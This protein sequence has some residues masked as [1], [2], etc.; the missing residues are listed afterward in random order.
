M[1]PTGVVV[2]RIAPLRRLLGVA[3]PGIFAV[4]IWWAVAASIVHREA[5]WPIRD[6]HPS[7]V[8]TVILWV[9]LL[10]VGWVLTYLMLFSLFLRQTFG[11]QGATLRKVR[12]VWEM[13]LASLTRI[14]FQGYMV[15]T[16]TT[17][18]PAERLVVHSDAGG[19]Y[20]LRATLNGGLTHLDEAFEVI[21]GW[22][23]LR[24]ELVRASNAEEYFVQRG[25]ASRR[26]EE[27]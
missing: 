22:V 21:D 19:R 9:L 26:P 1:T 7:T 27:G 8:G 5:D 14:E 20:P 6:M 2:V 16:G 13:P 24:P 4:G 18:L 25:A 10:P 15:H 23:R 17:Q 12:R 11:P 3:L